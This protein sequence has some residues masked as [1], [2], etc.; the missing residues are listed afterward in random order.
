MTVSNPAQ[1]ALAILV[2]QGRTEP[3]A[4]VLSEKRS[5]ENRAIRLNFRLSRVVLEMRIASDEFH[6]LSPCTASEV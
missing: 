2:R 5:P 3:M 4:S 6:N 1:P